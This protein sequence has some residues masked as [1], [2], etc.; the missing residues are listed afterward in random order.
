MLLFQ[1]R[2]LQGIVD[3][4]ITLTFR[5]WP[6]AQV[7][8]G[9][10]YRTHPIGVVEVGAVERVR[11]AD[12]SQ[13]DARAA[14][15][16]DRDE[17]LAYLEPAA[18][19]KFGPTTEVFRIE[20]RHAGDGDWVPLSRASDLSDEDI[21]EIDRRLARLD[22]EKPWTR[23]TLR[24]IESRPRVAASKLAAELGREKS[25]FKADVV[26]LKKL[27]LTES[28]EVGYDLSP[29]GKAYWNRVKRRRG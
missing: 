29:R 1:K 22:G 11:V 14:G 9:G 6:K 21:A 27:G 5:Q 24:L 3:G 26:K 15:F 10:R 18:R 28:F 23:A 19:E 12:I 7:K 25:D 20:F 13:A 8:P 2:F 4:A 16:A 17:L